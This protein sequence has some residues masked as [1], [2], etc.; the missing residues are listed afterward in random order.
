MST[1]PFILL[2]GRSGSGKDC[3]AQGLANLFGYKQVKSYTT[4]PQRFPEEDTHIF[5]DPKS[6]TTVASDDTIAATYFDEFW[7]W[8]TNQQV[9][10]NDVFVIDIPGVEY[11][12]EH[13]KGNKRIIICYIECEPGECFIRMLN[14]GDTINSAIDR[15]RNDEFHFS[16]EKLDEFC[17]KYEVHRFYNGRGARLPAIVDS[18]VRL[19][20]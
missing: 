7:Y 10:E 3:V 9:E 1:K 8:A 2:V 18:I 16:K 4:R 19:V 17:S 6:I 14:R 5:I 20:I 15:M 11:F 12:F 13:Y